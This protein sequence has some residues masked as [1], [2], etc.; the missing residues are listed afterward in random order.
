MFYITPSH[1]Q[2][3]IYHSL[4]YTSCGAVAERIIKA[5]ATDLDGIRYVYSAYLKKII[6]FTQFD[7]QTNMTVSD[8]CKENVLTP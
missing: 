6:H 2:D 7:Q 1:R 4:N 5:K 3:S 8:V